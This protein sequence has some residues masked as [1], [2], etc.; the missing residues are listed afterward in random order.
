MF[1]QNIEINTQGHLTFAG[2]D[3]VELA[4]KYG[5]PLYLLDEQ[6]IRS[7][8]RMYTETLKDCVEEALPLYASKALSCKRVYEIIKEEGMG[9]D[10][11]SAG[12]LYLA[13][14]AGFPA[15]KIF[16][17]GNS[18]P[19]QEIEF[20]VKRGVGF[21]VVDSREE[22]LA[23]NRIAGEAGIC[24]KILLRVTPGIDTHTFAAVRTGQ[25][26]SKFGMPIETGQAMEF[27]RLSLTMENLQVMGLHCHIGSQIF[28]SQ[29]FLDCIQIMVRFM[30]EAK[31]TLNYSTKMLNL[32]GGYGVR[33]REE[34]PMVDI[35]G[36][37]REVT[38]RLKE[39]CSKA[40]I[41]VPMVLMEPGRSIIADTGMTLYHVNAIKRI[42]G[43]KNY[44][45]I[46]GGM[47]DNPRFALYQSPY[48]VMLANKADQPVAF[49]ASIAGRCCESGD[50]IQENVMLP[51]TER[52]DIVAVM[53]TGAYNYSMASNYNSV[54]RPPIV[55]IN[56]GR[57]SVAV[58]RE[59]FEDLAARE[60]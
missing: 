28:E 48:T 7:N 34:D 58:R 57:A 50:M 15:D 26:D 22:I 36:S 41:T 39:L 17:H 59:T 42:T 4:Q 31:H 14:Q 53:V 27:L 60:V 13:L 32:G 47:T 20:A 3:T 6:R 33:Y 2:M 37:I 18:K 24:Q 29:P 9:T 19:E 5:T 10:V 16:F 56:H 21:F 46:D 45:A 44:V 25:V 52:G 12:E 51:E 1:L 54:C 23:L 11:V 43:F 38:G 40:E 30:T 55:T 8:C 35:P 49:C